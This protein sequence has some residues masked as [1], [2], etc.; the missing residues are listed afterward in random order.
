MAMTGEPHS[1]TRLPSLK[2]D[3]SALYPRPVVSMI[4]TTEPDETVLSRREGSLEKPRSCR[5]A[6]SIVVNQGMKHAVQHQVEGDE[7]GEPGVQERIGAIERPDAYRKNRQERASDPGS[8]AR[9]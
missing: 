8:E 9:E 5:T 2:R 7:I 1:S 3:L 4:K 6:F